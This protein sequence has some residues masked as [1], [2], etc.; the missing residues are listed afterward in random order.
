MH[1]VG[2]YGHHFVK[3]LSGVWESHEPVKKVYF[4]IYLLERG[5]SSFALGVCAV[6]CVVKAIRRR[7]KKFVRNCDRKFSR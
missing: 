5:A 1:F 2:Q 3:L 6:F 4:A 7:H